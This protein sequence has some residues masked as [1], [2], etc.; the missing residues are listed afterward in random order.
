MIRA[1]L[2]MVQA[3]PLCYQRVLFVISLGFNY[4]CANNLN[5]ILLRI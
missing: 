4:F 3:Q 1:V 5:V 2:A